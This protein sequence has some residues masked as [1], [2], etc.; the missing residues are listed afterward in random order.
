MS[1]PQLPDPLHP[2]LVLMATSAD[3]LVQ[4]PGNHLY[5]SQNYFVKDD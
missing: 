5:K 4:N 3:L 2:V 1:T